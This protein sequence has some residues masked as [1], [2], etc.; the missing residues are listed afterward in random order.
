[1]YW[2]SHRKTFSVQSRINGGW[3]VTDYIERDLFIPL[4]QCTLH[5]STSGRDRVRDTKRKNVHAWIDGY[6]SAQ[7]NFQDINVLDVLVY[8]PYRDDTFMFH[9]QPA[10]TAHRVWV[11]VWLNQPILFAEGVE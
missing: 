11:G 9:G 7:D 3:R 6:V 8:N 1:M 4:I 10:Q 2:N 5:V